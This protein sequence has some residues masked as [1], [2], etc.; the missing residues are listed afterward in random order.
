MPDA[1]D[2]EIVTLAVSSVDDSTEAALVVTAPSGVTSTPT[3]TSSNGRATWTAQVTYTTGGVWALKWTVTGTGK[4]TETKLVAVAPAASSGRAYATSAHLAEWL[5]VAP[6]LD[7]A[8][9]LRDATLEIDFAL[10][11]ATYDVDDDGE[12]TDTE[13]I[14]AFR[15]ACC[16]VVEWWEETGDPLNAGG[17]YNSV[18]IGSVTLSRTQA[19]GAPASEVLGRRA[20]NILKGCPE[21]RFGVTVL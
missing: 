9:Q 15:E 11:T 2:T 17:A 20:L 3:V 1:G 19:S 16:A 5:G 14:A 12:P 21:V 18:S 13:V 7:S 6:P 8:K 10:Q 4:G